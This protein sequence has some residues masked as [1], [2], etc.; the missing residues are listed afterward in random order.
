MKFDGVSY[1]AHTWNND[2]VFKMKSKWYHT[3]TADDW[4]HGWQWLKK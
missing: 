2:S 4:Y 1:E 3:Y